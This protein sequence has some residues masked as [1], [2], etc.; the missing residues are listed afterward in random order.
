[1]VRFSPSR[2]SGKADAE[3]GLPPVEVL[4]GERVGRLVR[5][6]VVAAVADG[7]ALHAAET[8]ADA[9]VDDVDPGLPGVAVARHACRE[10][11]VGSSEPRFVDRIR[12]SGILER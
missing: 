10:A 5:A 1:M 7:V 4:A 12:M 9:G 6:A 11:L 8:E 2:P 3:L